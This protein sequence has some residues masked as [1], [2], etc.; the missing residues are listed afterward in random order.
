MA[1]KSTAPAKVQVYSAVS[2]KL[3]F[4]IIKEAIQI[5]LIGGGVSVLLSLVGM[6]LAFAQRDIIQN[7]FSMGHL[8]FLA[9]LFIAGYSIASRQKTERSPWILLLLGLI[10]GLTG[11]AVLAGLV[12]LG[13][14]VNLRTMFVNASPALYQVLIFRQD[15]PLGLVN[16]ILVGSLTAT[17][18]V[19]LFLLPDRLRKAVL[20]AALWV[21]LLGLL[22]D[23]LI[24]VIARWGPVRPLVAWLFATRGLTLIGAATLFLLIGSLTYWRTGTVGPVI[25]VRTEAGR[26]IVR[27]TGIGVI[28]LILL[29]LPSITGIFFSEVLNQVGL[30][31]LM[32]L[33]LNIVVGFAGLLDLGHVAFFAIGA[34]TMGIMTSPELGFYQLTFWQALPIALATSAFAGWLLGLPVLRLRGDYLAIVTLGFGEIVRLLVLSDWLR[35]LLGGTQGIQ[36]IARPWVGPIQIVNQQQLYYLLLVG[37]VIT[38]FIA[39]R[40][41]DSRVGR[42]WMA[43]REDEDVARAMGINLVKY[44]LMAFTVSAAMAGLAGTIFAAKLTSVYPHSFNLLISINVLSLIIIGGMGSIPGV[45]VGALALVGL[46]ELLREFAEYRLLVYGAVL[47]AM[48]LMRP[49][50]LW[51][52]ERRKLE[53]HDEEAPSATADTR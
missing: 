50:G 27:F 40:L 42:A 17:A 29:T 14:T 38:S 43:V 44:K 4:R 15:L 21:I 30:F 48:M 52:E 5:G 35:P 31:I 2:G 10:A 12:L 39:F 19:G 46:P 53:L 47:V 24:T 41:K 32:G 9:P 13:Q 11:A 6:V 7:L 28:A 37:I 8:L 33:G 1:T 36:L 26:Q 25:P 18:G 34:Y 23:L 45:F 51:P 16:L 49:E 20:Q 3:R 22:R